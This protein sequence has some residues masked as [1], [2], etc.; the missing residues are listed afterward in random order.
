MR[1][2]SIDLWRMNSNDEL[3]YK[4]QYSGTF[5]IS[6][7]KKFC[8]AARIEQC[9][10]AF[11]NS[12]LHKE[13]VLEDKAVSSAYYCDSTANAQKCTKTSPRNLLTNNWLLRFDNTQSH[14]PFLTRDFFNKTKITV[15]PH[16]L[17]LPDL[18]S[19]YFSQFPRFRISSLWD[20]WGDRGRIKGGAEHPHK[21]RLPGCI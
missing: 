20:N 4:Q 5:T 16:P 10:Y 1:A 21:T 19:C 17:Y 14:I 7:T 11:T 8:E 2:R 13:F 6:G 3:Q 12:I 15:V 18:A 9:H